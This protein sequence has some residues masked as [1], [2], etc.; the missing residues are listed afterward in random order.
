MIYTV[1]AG[2][3]P[4]GE[5]TIE[6]CGLY[7]EIHGKITPCGEVRRL[8]GIRATDSVCL[9][10]PDKNGELHRRVSQRSFTL[11]ERVILS[12]TNSDRWLPWSGES[13]GTMVYDGFLCREENGWS[14]AIDPVEWENIP[15]WREN[16]KKETVAGRPMIRVNLGM[17]GQPPLIK[18]DNGGEDN[19]IHTQNHSNALDPLLLADLPA[20]YDYGGTG[21]EEAHSD[22]L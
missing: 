6:A 5:I 1:Y 18:K 3:E 10:I 9:G 14:L 2:K 11:P 8:Y 22:Y 4:V 12:G 16:G 13:F 15:Q 20:D 7:F 17:D 19:E 21:S